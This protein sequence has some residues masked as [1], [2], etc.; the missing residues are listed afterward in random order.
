MNCKTNV[1]RNGDICKLLPNE[2][3]YTVILSLYSTASL[4]KV[5]RNLNKEKRPRKDT[6]ANRPHERIH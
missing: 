6:Q 4:E 5:S 2:I 1:P 3:C